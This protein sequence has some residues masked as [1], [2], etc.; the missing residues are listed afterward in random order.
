MKRSTCYF[1]TLLALTFFWSSAGAQVSTYERTPG[2]YIFGI[3][4][5]L[6]YQQADIPTTLQGYGLGFT[7]GK[8]LY[9]RPGSALSFDIRG[10]ALYSQTH[11]LDYFRSYGIQDNDALNGIQ[12]LDYTKEGGGPG[13]VF[14]NNK[15]DHAELGIEGVINFNKLREQTNVILSLYGGIGLDWYNARTDQADRNGL[16]TADYEGIDTLASVSYIKKKLR[17]EILDGRYESKASD[18]GRIG[19]MPSLGVELGYQLSPRFSMGV[20]HKVT[21][22]NTDLFDGH[23]WRNDGNL[24][25]D[26]DIHHYTNLHMRWIIDD[27]SRKLREPFV[28]ITNPALSPHR[29]RNSTIEIRANTRHV[30]SAIDVEFTVNGYRES[31]DFRRNNFKSFIRLQPGNNEVVIRVS[32]TV[33]TASDMVNIFYEEPGT[34]TNPNYAYPAVEII[35]PP[36]RD[37]RTDNDRF[38]LR[39]RLDNVYRGRDINLIVNGRSTDRFNF[40]GGSLSAML[41]LEE[42]R[43]TVRIEARNQDGFA[44]D[45]SSIILERSINQQPPVVNITRPSVDPYLTDDRDVRI[46]AEIYNVMDRQDIR[47]TVDGYDVYDFDFNNGIF[48]STLDINDPQTVV[49]ISARNDAGQS[50]DSVVI[51]WEEEETIDAPVVTITSISTPTTDPFNPN[52]CKSTIIATI[53]NVED[54]NDID[55]YLNGQ[56]LN[57]YNFDSDTQVF[58]ITVQLDRGE[59]TIRIEATNAGGSDED[60]GRIEGCTPQ[61]EEKPPV[62]TITTPQEDNTETNKAQAEVKATILNIVSRSDISFELNG[63]TSNDFTFDK[64]TKVFRA[65]ITLENGNNTVFIKAENNDGTASDRRNIFYK[66][67]EIIRPPQVDIESPRNNSIVEKALVTLHAEIKNVS[68]R[69]DIEVFLNGKRI[70]NFSFDKQSLE[71]ELDLVRGNNTIRV[72]A[73]NKAGTDEE[74]VNVKYM[75]PRPKPPVVDI[76]KPSTGVVSNKRISLIASIKNVDN[77]R[78]IEVTVN[79]R[80]LGNFTFNGEELRASFDA[81]FGNNVIVVKASNQGGSD[82]DEVIVVYER[83][84]P[85]APVVDITKPVNNISTQSADISVKALI[86]NVINKNDI[87]LLVN[88][89]AVRAFNYQR[90]ELSAEIKLKAGKNNIRVKA[91]NA[92]GSDQ[93]EVVVNY[94]KPLNPPRVEITSPRNNQTFDKAEV[95][96]EAK[97][98]HVLNQRNVSVNLNGKRQRF[99]YSRGNLRSNLKL[100]PG[101]NTIVIK[102]TNKDGNDEAS[103]TINYSP[104]LEIPKPIA[105]F[106]KP[107]KPGAITKKANYI[108]RATAKYVNRAE[109]IALILNGKEVKSFDFNTRTKAIKATVVLKP[110]QNDIYLEAKNTTGTDSKRSNVVYQKV[111]KKKVPPKVEII[112]IS[113]PTVDPFNPDKAKSTVLA[114]IK[115]VKS[116]S[117]IEFLFNGTRINNFSYNTRSGE[118]QVTLD[119]KRGNNTFVI[120]A[121]NKD[122]KD[123]ASRNIEFA[124]STGN[125]GT[126]SRNDHKNNSGTTRKGPKSRKG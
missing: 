101:K 68:D 57:N 19:I 40:N 62:V 12:N 80:P 43:N 95:E 51:L 94:N 120:K 46:E 81:Q 110:G 117:G 25:A 27:G 75:P 79:G 48:R 64:F 28:E 114:K 107:A 6:A 53:L 10:R 34:N 92:G 18:F 105:G 86:E 29:T 121:T 50:N 108:I 61:Q 91:V 126:S 3:N 97:I 115:H 47:Y 52:N 17:N 7:L 85:K 104:K 89:K 78:G 38:E 58:T 76:E 113:T 100:S 123:E 23:Q 8:N 2:Y 90:G 55:V 21:F 11:G 39:A 65:N 112:S 44:S 111:S 102:A 42:G 32:N 59:N 49:N 98:K 14:Q 71:T 45:E 74:R 103:I 30:A 15:T 63:K 13:F 72:L 67:I 119:L 99:D 41:D 73:S 37:F 56:S 84:R 109:D 69:R 96:L 35:N 106:S 116:K 16:Y 1:Y 82:R 36:Y 122:G 5:G 70:N 87:R 88:G 24:T 54:R 31:F 77:K 26:D 125:G 83:P 93:D 124:G 118:L 22:T 9:Y 60:T 20:G 33:G 66:K 4:G